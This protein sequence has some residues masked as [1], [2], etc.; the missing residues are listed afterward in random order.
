M[1]SE[2]TVIILTKNESAH[3]ERCINSVSTIAQRI[4]LIDSGSTDNTC[5]IASKLGADVYTNPF[6]SHASQFNWALENVGVK[7]CWVMKLDAD[8]Y[9]TTELVDALPGA[10]LNANSSVAG[11]TIN[12]RRVFMGKFLRFGGLYPIRLLRVWR[13][14]S[15]ILDN[16]LMDEH[17]RVRGAVEHLDFDFVDEN[18][19][20]LGWWIDK[21]NAYAS[22]E[23]VELLNLEYNFLAPKTSDLPTMDIAANR[24][25]WIKEQ[26][27]FRMPR[28][29][30]AFGYFCYRYFCLLGILDGKEGAIFHVLQG[31][32][33]RYLVDAKVYEVKRRM[34]ETS[35]DAKTAIKNALGIVLD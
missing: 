10:I 21:H 35:E 29:I 8:E 19:N 16:R 22:K 18:L 5:D 30:R 2:L 17:V 24:K 13:H 28:G 27:Y 4:V 31:F 3:I 23:A 9:L 7:T 33:Y 14:N 6:T 32:W 15:G 12:L 1:K 25:R 11:F 34:R 20:S 26:V